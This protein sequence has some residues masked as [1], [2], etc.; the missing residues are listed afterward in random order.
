MIHF[1]TKNPLIAIIILNLLL[2]ASMVLSI[3]KPIWISNPE[4]L[5]YWTYQECEDLVRLPS[6]ISIIRCHIT[7]LL[8]LSIDN[9][10]QYSLHFIKD[11]AQ[12]WEAKGVCTLSPPP[13]LQIISCSWWRGL[14]ICARSVSMWICDSFTSW[15]VCFLCGSSSK[16]KQ[17]SMLYVM[18]M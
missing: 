8:L 3:C 18:W 13:H 4:I 2:F 6:L 1:Q 12:R 7:S 15:V 9:W 11:A 10:A 5:V 14:C 16:S 17:C